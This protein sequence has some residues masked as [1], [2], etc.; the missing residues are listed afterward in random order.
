MNFSGN[1]HRKS[2]RVK[3]ESPIINRRKH[4]DNMS[5]QIV[6]DIFIPAGASVEVSHNL[7]MTPEY[8]IILRQRSSGIISDGDKPWTDKAIY[9]KNNGL[10]DDTITILIMRD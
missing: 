4:G 5:G 2:Q 3:I 6:K 8:R 7:K 9:L 1:Q 10:L